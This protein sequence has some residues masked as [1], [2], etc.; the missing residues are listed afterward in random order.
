MRIAY[1]IFSV[2]LVAIWSLVS[3]EP[4]GFILWLT[5]GAFLTTD[6]TQ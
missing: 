2:L 5:L 3:F 1:G 6:Y 4:A